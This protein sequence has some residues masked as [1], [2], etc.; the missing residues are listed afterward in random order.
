MLE[1]ALFLAIGLPSL[2]ASLRYYED[3][4]KAT[5]KSEDFYHAFKLF[6]V[7]LFIG[8]LSIGLYIGFTIAENNIA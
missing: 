7:F 2:F 6:V 8:T 3:L 1:K 5:P 4:R